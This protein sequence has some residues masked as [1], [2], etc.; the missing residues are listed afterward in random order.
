[1]VAVAVG[2]IGLVSLIAIRLD[3]A[4]LPNLGLALEPL[5]AW[6]RTLGFYLA[7]P[8]LLALVV[9]VV[10]LFIHGRLGVEKVSAGPATITLPPPADLV[11]CLHS[12][13]CHCR[14]DAAD[15]ENSDGMDST[16]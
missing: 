16:Q 15:A 2:V 8:L 5:P 9:L 1:M 13:A 11:A 4:A 7:I 10:R 3:I 6:A 14:A 12:L